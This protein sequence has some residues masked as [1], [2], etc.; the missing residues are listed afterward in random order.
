MLRFSS[1]G[2]ES[3]LAQKGLLKNRKEYFR[4]RAGQNHRVLALV[5]VAEMAGGE[6][7]GHLCSGGKLR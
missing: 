1:H 4:G 6:R 5:G 2:R 7:T 3:H